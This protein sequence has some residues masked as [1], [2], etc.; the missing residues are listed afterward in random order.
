MKIIPYL[1]VF[2]IFSCNKTPVEI[3][4]KFTGIKYYSRCSRYNHPVRLIG[5]LTLKD[6]KNQRAYFVG[7]YRK[8]IL[9]RAEKILDEKF[10]YSYIYEYDSLGNFIKINVDRKKR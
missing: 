6:T 2:I 3:E 10:E 5:E 8:G 9:L 7:Y 1:F 4:K